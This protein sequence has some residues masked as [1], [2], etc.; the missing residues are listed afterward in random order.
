MLVIMNPFRGHSQNQAL[1]KRKVVG[2]IHFCVWRLINTGKR[3]R[4]GNVKE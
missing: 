3:L 2:L 4:P 1:I